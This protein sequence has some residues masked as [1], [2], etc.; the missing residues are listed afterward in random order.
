MSLSGKAV[1]FVFIPTLA[2]VDQWPD[3]SF[4]GAN[5]P[6]A[7]CLPLTFTADLMKAH[8][9]IKQYVSALV[10]HLPQEHRI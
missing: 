3:P 1:W 8:E 5:S 6:P 10:L 4:N 9:E 2:E 7:P